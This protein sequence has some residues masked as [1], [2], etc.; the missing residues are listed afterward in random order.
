MRLYLPL[1]E[2]RLVKKWD[3]QA[4]RSLT[5]IHWELRDEMVT[6]DQADENTLT[7]ST[8]AELGNL[9]TLPTSPASQRAGSVGTRASK[10]EIGA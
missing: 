8:A 6:K 9:L 5:Q 3:L 7:G 10:L 1:D 2:R 4:S